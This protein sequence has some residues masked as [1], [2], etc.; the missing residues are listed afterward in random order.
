[1]KIGILDSGIGGLTVLKECLKQIPNHNYLYFADSKNAPYG[2]RPKN[3]VLELTKKSVSFLIAK[4]AEIIVIAC[5][6]ATSVAAAELRE[7]YNIPIIGMEPAVKPALEQASS[8]RVLVTAT[9][10]TLKSDKFLEL[11]QTLDA[12]KVVDLCPLPQLVEFAE[13]GEFSIEKVLPYLRDAFSTFDLDLYGSLVLG[14]THFPL[15]R[16]AFERILSKK[17]LIFDGS[18]GT[19]KRIREFVSS[20][21]SPPSI[22]LFLSG[23]PLVEGQLFDRI[24]LIL[25]D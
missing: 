10:L 2:T 6:T 18:Y 11:V 1:M 12:Q 20:E 4:G 7:I 24:Q 22:Q 17:V 16:S 13:T 19:V 21:S 9:E 8:K 5:N 3:Q 25:K 23:T 14:C 15:Y